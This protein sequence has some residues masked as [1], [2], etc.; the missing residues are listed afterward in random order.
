MDENNLIVLK[1]YD[2]VNNAEWERSLLEGAG[3]WAMVRNEIMSAIYPTGVIPAQ[4]IIRK[5]DKEKA[6]EILE[7]YSE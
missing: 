2:S 6:S 7:A 1:E 5:Q 3:I 4:L